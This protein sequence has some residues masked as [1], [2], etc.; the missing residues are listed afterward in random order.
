MLLS[1]YPERMLAVFVS[2]ICMLV[3]WWRG[4]AGAG[5][6][7]LRTPAVR[8][9]ILSLLLLWRVVLALLWRCIFRDDYA[10]DS[11]VVHDRHGDVC[12]VAWCGGAVDVARRHS[13]VVVCGVGRGW[14]WSW[15]RLLP[16]APQSPR[17]CSRCNTSM[18]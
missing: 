13:P 2:V 17:H 15:C 14:F 11:G 18:Q 8:N 6:G 1:R 7:E 10:F 3:W 4:Q 16:F 9:L 5:L 12:E